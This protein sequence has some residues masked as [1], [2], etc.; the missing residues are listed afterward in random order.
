VDTIPPVA[1][2]VETVNPHGKQIPKAPAEGGQGQNQDG[3]YQ[4]LAE[5]NLVEECAP[6]DLFITDTGSGT[7][8]GPYAVGTNI[9]YTEDEYATP[10]AKKIGSAKGQAGAVYVHIIGNGDAALTAVDESGNTSEPVACLVPP[11]PK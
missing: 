3:Y 9:K 6:L 10:E 11:P 4:L 7:V 5:D 2:C 8:F 1:Q